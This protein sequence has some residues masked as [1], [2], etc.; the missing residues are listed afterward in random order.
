MYLCTYIFTSLLY[1]QSKFQGASSM[2]ICCVLGLHCA[3]GLNY[4][5]KLITL[6][7]AANPIERVIEMVKRWKSQLPAERRDLTTWKKKKEI[8]QKERRRLRLVLSMIRRRKTV[9]I[10]EHWRVEPK[11][12]SNRW[13]KIVEKPV[14]VVGRNHYILIPSYC[15]F[16]GKWFWG[17]IKQ[18]FLCIPTDSS[19]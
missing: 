11:A 9:G 2:T 14:V 16:M 6:T 13:F 1:N 18:I 19:T 12:H 10:R 4:D 5:I 17:K 7:V 8:K 3:S 15:L